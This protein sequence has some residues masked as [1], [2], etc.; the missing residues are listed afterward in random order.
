MNDDL[1]IGLL[2]YFLLIIKIEQLIKL[3]NLTFPLALFQVWPGIVYFAQLY[4]ELIKKKYNA[5]VSTLT[6]FSL[7]R[8]N[9][10]YFFVSE[11]NFIFFEGRFYGFG[12]SSF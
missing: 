5:M 11:N 2:I 7:F 3:K 1:I 10:Y 4:V 9:F 6:L 8:I 12:Y